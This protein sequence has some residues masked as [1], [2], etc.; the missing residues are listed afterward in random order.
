MLIR[1]SIEQLKQ[2]LEELSDRKLLLFM[3]S[4]AERMIPSYSAFS[5]RTRFGDVSTLRIA[6]DLAWSQ[7]DKE[8][9]PPAVAPLVESCKKLAPDT[10][11]FVDPLVS[12]ALDSA[13]ATVLVVESLASPELSANNALEVAVLARDSVD[14]FVQE[15]EALPP[16]AVDLEDRI[17][18]H[19]LMQRELLYQ[20]ETAENL[21]DS[22]LSKAIPEMRNRWQGQK[23][24]NIGQEM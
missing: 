6:L 20:K 2:A 22:D 7:L 19:A 15:C 5:R 18:D 3:L 14:L 16:G 11:D 8:N 21:R 24:S 23:I 9:G 12:S 1:Y 10:E 4:C 13:V 17:R